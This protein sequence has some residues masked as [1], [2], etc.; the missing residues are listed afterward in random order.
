M[1]DKE[2]NENQQIE[3]MKV[4]VYKN[5][6]LVEE[7]V[8]KPRAVCEKLDGHTQFNKDEG[9]FEEFRVEEVDDDE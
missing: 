2:A 9:D 5:G 8:E 7:G 1:T 4:N 6:E 3:T